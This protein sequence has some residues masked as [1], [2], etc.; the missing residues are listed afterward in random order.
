MICINQVDLVGSIT[1]CKVNHLR[2]L[3][4]QGRSLKTQLTFLSIFDAYS[5][6]YLESSCLFQVLDQ[7]YLQPFDKFDHHYLHMAY[8][9]PWVLQQQL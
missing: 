9:G 6:N 7:N 1:K 3:K 4:V 2:P 5:I 8:L